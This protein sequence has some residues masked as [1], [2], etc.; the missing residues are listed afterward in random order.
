MANHHFSKGEAIR[1]GWTT[2]KDNL[3][4]FIKI[5]LPVAF[6]FIGLGIMREALEESA[7]VASFAISMV[8]WIFGIFIGMGFIKIVLD[9]VDGRKPIMDQFFSQRLLFF[10][11]FWT[12]IL[13]GL[14]VFAGFLLLIIPGLIWI[15]K[16]QFAAY[17]VID[18][19]IGPRDAIRRSGRITQGAK[20]DLFLLSILLQW[21][22][23]A[24]I[25]F[26]VVGLFIT[27]PVSMLATAY[28]YRTLLNQEEA[29]SVFDT[30]D[31]KAEKA[32]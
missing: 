32:V 31:I 13:Y 11:Y 18:K 23:M 26:F 17:L 16:Y 30:G 21:I 28:V 15:F 12:S 29:G 22:N 4:L 5:L 1:F 14:I 27:I 10:K 9:L 19:G 24:G 3:S 6:I 2:T 8:S 25:L 7:P 20:W